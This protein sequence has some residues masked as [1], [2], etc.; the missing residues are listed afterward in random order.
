MKPRTMIQ[1]ALFA[2]TTTLMQA[3][4]VQ[5]DHATMSDLRI[6]EDLATGGK[7][8]S[9]WGEGLFGENYANGRQFMPL[10]P[11]FTIVEYDASRRALHMAG[12]IPVE[13][14]GN[15]RPAAEFV[16]G[17]GLLNESSWTERVTMHVRQTHPVMSDYMF[18]VVITDV[19]SDDWVGLG[20]LPLTAKAGAILTYESQCPIYHVGKLV[21]MFPARPVPPTPQQSAGRPTIR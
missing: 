15:V 20:M 9:Y 10:Q 6:D 5:L 12:T 2:L 19:A 16:V 17:S 21:G 11:A 13:F 4:I 1:L 3:Q 18:D 8:L 7:G 14:Q